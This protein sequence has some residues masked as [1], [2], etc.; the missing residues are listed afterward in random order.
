LCLA[1]GFLATLLAPSPSV[2][3][4]PL[5]VIVHHGGSKSTQRIEGL[6]WSSQTET[7]PIEWK[8]TQPEVVVRGIFLQGDSNLICQDQRIQVSRGTGEFQLAIPIQFPH[9]KIELIAISPRGVVEKESL[10]VEASSWAAIQ[11]QTELMHKERRFK[12]TPSLGVTSFSYT[13][14]RVDDYSATAL[15]IKASGSYIFL[16]PRWDFSFSSYVTAYLLSHSEPD[17]AHFFGLNFRVG[18]LLPWLSEPW[19]LVIS[20]GVYYTTMF[21]S[22]DR[23]G[24]ENLAGPQLYPT[25]RRTLSRGDQISVYAKYSP[26]SSGSEGFSFSSR[27]VAFGAGYVFP[28]FRNGHTISA[29]FDYADIQASSLDIS[30]HSS[31]FTLGVGYAL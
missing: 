24:F 14:P 13:D 12:F 6:S 17:L 11:G 27:E 15:T 19:R 9:Q 26:V 3:Q 8:N 30:F 5:S 1:L 28:R 7:L 31:S 23:F 2:A 29:S 4:D 18:Y 21:V 20:G 10:I 16:P 22:T 25:L